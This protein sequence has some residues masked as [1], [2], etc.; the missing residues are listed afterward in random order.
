VNAGFEP[1]REVVTELPE[2]VMNYARKRFDLTEGPLMRVATFAEARDNVM[3]VMVLHHAVCD[4]H[5]LFVLCKRLGPNI[6]VNIFKNCQ[7]TSRFA[8]SI[9]D[10]VRYQK[11]WLIHPMP[12]RKLHIGNGYLEGVVSPCGLPTDRVNR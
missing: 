5:S 10:F 6:L 11:E 2:L 4:G 12:S 3:L 8:V 7:A 1:N 9:T